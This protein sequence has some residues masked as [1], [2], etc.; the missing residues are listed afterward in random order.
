M[1]DLLDF[2]IEKNVD[3]LRFM[4]EED[5]NYIK[6]LP[7]GAQQVAEKKSKINN[8]LTKIQEKMEVKIEMNTKKE[9]E[10]YLTRFM[11]SYNELPELK[12]LLNPIAPLIFQFVITDRPEMNYWQF[13]D[14]DK[15]KWGMGEYSGP[16]TSKL[17]YKT[18][19]E[20]IKRVHSGETDPIQAVMAKTYFVEGDVS[21]LMVCGPLLPLNAKAHSKAV[22]NEL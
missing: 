15:V 14:K 19:F 2:L 12:S 13:L 20:T 21:K 11:K 4:S 3:L 17:I 6:S 7:Y 5:I 10:N 9:W 16:N 18:D 8:N 1:H 22:E